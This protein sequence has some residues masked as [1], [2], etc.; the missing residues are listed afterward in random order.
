MVFFYLHY[1]IIIFEFEQCDGIFD[2]TSHLSFW[3]NGK[4][5]FIDLFGFAI[6]FLIIDQFMEPCF[7]AY[8]VYIRVVVK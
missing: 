5:T 1:I 6:N 8:F 4:I 7:S 2:K 3:E